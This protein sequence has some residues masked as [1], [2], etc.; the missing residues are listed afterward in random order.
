MNI[1]NLFYLA[2]AFFTSLFIDTGLLD[3]AEVFSKI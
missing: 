1:V 3:A 2:S